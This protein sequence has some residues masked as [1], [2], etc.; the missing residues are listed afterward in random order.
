MVE[1][2]AAHL[3]IESERDR[4]KKQ[5]LASEHFY[6]NLFKECLYLK[7]STK[8]TI[9][10]DLICIEIKKENFLHSIKANSLW[11]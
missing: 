7:G 3:R 10:I 8:L 11:P 1:Y 2:L 9:K 4:E 5:I 6:S